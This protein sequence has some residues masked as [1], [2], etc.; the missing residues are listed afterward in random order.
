LIVSLN[1]RNHYDFSILQLCTDTMT[2]ACINLLLLKRSNMPTVVITPLKSLLVRQV[3]VSN[4]CPTTSPNRII[5]L[6]VFTP[7]NQKPGSWLAD[8]RS[9]LQTGPV[10]PK[11]LLMRRMRRN[12]TTGMQ[13]MLELRDTALQCR[14]SHWSLCLSGCS[15]LSKLV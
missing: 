11:A 6:V 3:I 12:Q 4:R 5:L 2:S 7:S 10:A 14:G 13:L 9:Y 1:C 8:F 15:P